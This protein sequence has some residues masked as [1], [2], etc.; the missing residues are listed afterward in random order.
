M[1]ILVGIWTSPFTELE[2]HTKIEY[3]QALGEQRQD[4]F[5][6]APPTGLETRFIQ[7]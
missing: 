6:S 1:P 4:Q 5:P 7:D 3:G 2:G